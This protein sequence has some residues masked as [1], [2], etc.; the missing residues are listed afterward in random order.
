MSEP[1]WEITYVD[2][3]RP[4]KNP[5]DPNYPDGKD[6]DASDGA[7][8]TCVGELPKTRERWCGCWHVVCRR[9]GYSAVVTTAGRPDDP[10]L[11][12]LPCHISDRL[13]PWEPRMP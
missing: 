10:R 2:R 4:A 3:G 5:P 7:E 11:L 9:C 8:K 1:D 13:D 12:K 6:I